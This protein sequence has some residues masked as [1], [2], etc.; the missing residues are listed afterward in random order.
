MTFTARHNRQYGSAVMSRPHMVMG[1]NAFMAVFCLS[2]CPS[3]SAQF[4]SVT[5]R[6]T[7]C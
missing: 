1:N 5:P 6:L 3:V 4:S 2:V 7:W